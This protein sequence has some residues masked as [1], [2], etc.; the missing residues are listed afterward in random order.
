MKGIAFGTAVNSGFHIKM[1]NKV[2]GQMS[3]MVVE[4]WHERVVIYTL[5]KA[6]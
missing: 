2:H 5:S 3:T 1:S 6:P 4:D